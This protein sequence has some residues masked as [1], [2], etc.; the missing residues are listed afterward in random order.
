[1][2]IR[3][4]NCVRLFLVCVVWQYPP[5]T[6]IFFSIFGQHTLLQRRKETPVQRKKGFLSVAQLSPACF[7]C[8]VLCAGWAD[9]DV[10]FPGKAKQESRVVRVMI[11]LHY[12]AP[13]HEPYQSE[14]KGTP[15]R[16]PFALR[17]YKY[18]LCSTPSGDI[19]RTHLTGEETGKPGET[20]EHTDP[21]QTSRNAPSHL[22]PLPSAQ[23]Q[24]Q[25]R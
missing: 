8:Y 24:A 19:L 9:R 14:K 7:L 22:G 1:M 23:I 5:I 2:C 10:C 17:S 12:I 4:R 18:N 15:Q 11:L 6:R 21:P 16:C 25:K 20:G 13:L 3:D